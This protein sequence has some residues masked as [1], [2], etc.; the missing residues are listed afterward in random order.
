[1][2]VVGSGGNVDCGTV[3]VV[4]PSG[5]V[6]LELAWVVSVPELEEPGTVVLVSDHELRVVMSNGIVVGNSSGRGNVVGADG[7]GPV[8]TV[9]LSEA[10]VEV[11][12]VVVESASVEDGASVVLGAEVVVEVGGLLELVGAS[13]ASV[14]GGA[15]EVT[16][17]VEASMLRATVLVSS[18][19]SPGMAITSPDRTRMAW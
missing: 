5:M 19:R 9:E 10:G 17:E 7:P 15:M 6:E 11:S 4:L 3:V 14:S 8:L 2:V 12:T 18:D 16:S 1:M 13:V